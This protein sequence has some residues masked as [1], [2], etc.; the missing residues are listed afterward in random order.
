MN[1]GKIDRIIRGVVG[2]ALIIVALFV[3]TG[4]WQIVSIVVGGILVG[5]ALSG[6]CPLYVPFHI[7]TKK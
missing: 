5:T 6:F 4:A 1:M 2:V 7:S 3:L